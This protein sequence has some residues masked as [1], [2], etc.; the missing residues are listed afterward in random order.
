[1]K[2]APQANP[3]ARS[4]LLTF[5]NRDVANITRWLDTFADAMTNWVRVEGL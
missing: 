1:M 2:K 3:G 4:V 5:M